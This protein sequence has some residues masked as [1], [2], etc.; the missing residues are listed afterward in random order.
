VLP[1]PANGRG[2]GSPGPRLYRD[3]ALM[4]RLSISAVVSAV[5]LLA[6]GST[7]AAKNPSPLQPEPTATAAGDIPD[8]Q[9]F[10]TFNNAQSRYTMKY[11]EGWAQQGSGALVTFRDKNNVVRIVVQKGGPRTAAAISKELRGMKVQ[12]APQ[13]TPL[14]SGKA[15]KVVYSSVSPP[16]PVTGKRVTLTVDR[17]YLPHGSKEAVVDLGTPVG[18]DNVD[19]Y[20]LM[21]ESLRWK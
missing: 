13:P 8:N 19:A 18:V 5:L 16:N 14:P 17:Y 20:R 21:I 2:P 3:N 12:K 11:P 6:V 7:A 15:F 1:V 4:G 9:L 10:V